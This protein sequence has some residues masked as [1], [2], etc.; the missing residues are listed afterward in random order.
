MKRNSTNKSVDVISISESWSARQEEGRQKLENEL[1]LQKEQT[2]TLVEKNEAV[3]KQLSE[4]GIYQSKHIIFNSMGNLKFFQF[5]VPS[6]EESIKPV[7][8][9]FSLNLSVFVPFKASYFFVQ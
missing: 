1:K 9:L 6:S 3:E 4:K 7:Y 2:N 5:A 8:L